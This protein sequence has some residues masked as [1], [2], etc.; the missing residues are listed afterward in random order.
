MVYL[1]FMEE[2]LAYCFLESLCHL[3]R[4]T[5]CELVARMSRAW[6]QKIEQPQE[7]Q[8]EQYDGHAKNPGHHVVHRDAS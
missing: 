1:H 4:L 2:I 8:K 5:H 6:T 7:K 3:I